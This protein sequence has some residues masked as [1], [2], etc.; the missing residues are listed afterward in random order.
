MLS[1]E[2]EAVELSQPVKVKD[3]PAEVWLQT[4]DGEMRTTLRDA[5]KGIST[6]GGG[7]GGAMGVVAAGGGALGGAPDVLC[8]T[9]ACQLLC[10]HHALRFT[11][12]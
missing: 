6:A 10:L 12:S 8:G 1:P 7:S 11:Q 5:L 3:A 9:V 4:L 2:G